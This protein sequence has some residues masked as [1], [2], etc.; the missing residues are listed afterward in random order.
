MTNGAMSTTFVVLTIK[1][2]RKSPFTSKRAYITSYMVD[3]FTFGENSSF[4][5]NILI[6]QLIDTLL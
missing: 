2:G 5:H 6:F 4:L 1:M 3:T